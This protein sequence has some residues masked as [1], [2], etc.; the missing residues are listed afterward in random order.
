MRD[1]AAGHNAE[2]DGFASVGCPGVLKNQALL[3][4]DVAGVAGVLEDSGIASGADRWLQKA[5]GLYGERGGTDCVSRRAVAKREV[6]LRAQFS[7][8]SL[9]CA[10]ARFMG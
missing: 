7:V 4:E 8:G 10:R 3:S 1:S 6:Q 2:R 9:G 5:E